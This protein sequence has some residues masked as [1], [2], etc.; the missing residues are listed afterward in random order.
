MNL[1]RTAG[2]YIGKNLTDKAVDFGDLEKNP[3]LPHYIVSLLIYVN[4]VLITQ[5]YIG[6]KPEA[7][8]LFS[9]DAITVTAHFLG[10]VATDAPVPIGNSPF[11]CFEQKGGKWNNDWLDN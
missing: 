1:T 5:A 6:K 3:S 9:V 11:L 8:I 7:R 4:L 2:H 10:A